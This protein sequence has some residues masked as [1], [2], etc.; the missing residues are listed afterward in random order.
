MHLIGTGF[1]HPIDSD[2]WYLPFASV[3]QSKYVME[4][5][6]FPDDVWIA[7]RA[8][9]AEEHKTPGACK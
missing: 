9:L 6:K 5:A 8:A 4:M 1:Q 7:K 2:F 3:R